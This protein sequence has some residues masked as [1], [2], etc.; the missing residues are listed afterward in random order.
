MT[1]YTT[2]TPEENEAFEALSRKQEAQVKTHGEPWVWL[3]EGE[4][5]ETQLRN[6]VKSFG[7]MRTAHAEAMRPLGGGH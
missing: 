3:A 7:R 5:T 6:L 2:P 1:T 4:Y